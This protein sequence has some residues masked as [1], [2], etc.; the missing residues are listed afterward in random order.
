MPDRRASRCRLAGIVGL[1]AYLP[2]VSRVHAERSEA[3]RNTRVFMGHGLY[4]PMVSLEVGDSSRKL[5]EE[6]E[7]DLTWR[8]YPMQHSICEQEMRDLARF[9]VDCLPGSIG[10][11]HG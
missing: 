9:F 4:D 7:Y 11:D 6:L 1:S 3:N 10:T 8:T 2:E 5:L